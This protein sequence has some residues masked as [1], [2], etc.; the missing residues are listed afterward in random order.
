MSE[1][2]DHQRPEHAAFWDKRFAEGVTPWAASG[3]P[4]DLMRHAGTVSGTP[5][6][7]IPGCGHA[8]EAAWLAERDWDVTALDFSSAA[9]AVA[10]RILAGSPVR[11]RHDDFFTFS[12]TAPFDLVYER[13]FLCALPRKCWPDYARRMGELVVPGGALIGVFFHGDDPKGPPFGITP[14]ALAELLAP[15][16]T[17]EDAR[18]VDDSLPVFAGRE[19]WYVWRRR[20]S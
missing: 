2:P 17:L 15:W 3:V 13:A 9:V 18:K 20:V 11:L 5:R 6:I 8:R 19:E 7:L 12:E 4:Q 10:A 1:K 16:F 14:A